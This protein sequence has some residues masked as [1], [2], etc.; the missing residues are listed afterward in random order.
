MTKMGAETLSELVRM[1]MLGGL[2]DDDLPARTPR[3]R[4]D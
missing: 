3:S 4:I 1:A 2:L